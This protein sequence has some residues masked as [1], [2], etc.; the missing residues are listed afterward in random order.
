LLFFSVC[1]EILLSEKQIL[2]KMAFF[3]FPV[4]ESLVIEC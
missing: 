1:F 4:Q 2:Y 3:S